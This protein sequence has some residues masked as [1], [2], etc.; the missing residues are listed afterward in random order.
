[1]DN[2]SSVSRRKYVQALL[3]STAAGLAGCN[4][5]GSEGSPGNESSA[6]Q[7]T[8]TA[9]TTSTE[10]PPVRES[11]RSWITN[12]PSSSNLNR[13]ASSTKEGGITWFRELTD[14]RII[15]EANRMVFSGESFDSPWI[16][17]A[18]SISIP[19]MVTDHEVDAP[20]DVYETYD[21]R[22]TYWDGTPLDAEARLYTDRL[23]YFSDG[24]KYDDT[25]TKNN[26][27][28]SQWEFHWWRNK[29][30]VEGQEPDPTN[31]RIL[32]SQKLTLP[33]FHPDF[34]T[35]WV[36]KFRDAS[37]QDEVD[38]INSDLQGR[39]IS[40]NE[41]ADNSW[42][43]GLYEIES[44]D[45]IS[46]ERLSATLR[47]D[48]PN[49]HAEIPELELHFANADRGQ[50]LRGEG[51]IDIGNGVITEDGSI[52][53]ESLPDHIQQVDQFLQNG[54]DQITF[55]L[56]NQHLAN[57]WVRRAIIAAVDW[58]QASINGF[59]PSGAVPN[60]SHA[61]MLQTTATSFFSEE[62]LDSLYDW[63]MGSD[64]ELAEKWMQKAGYT[65]E[66]GIWTSP[67]G[68]Q[69]DLS[70]LGH[71]DIPEWSSFI[72]TCQQN[73]QNL[74]FEVGV[75]F[76]D[77][78]AWNNAMKPENL[79]YDLAMIWTPG[80]TNPWDAYWTNGVFWSEPLVGGDP[81]DRLPWQVDPET[82]GP[83]VTHD[84]KDMQN[85]PLEV[86]IP[87]NPSN[88]DAAPNEAGRVPDLSGNAVN[89]DVADLVHSLRAPD[90]TEEE[91]RENARKCAR[92]YNFYLPN[93]HFHQ[94]T[95]GLWGNV[96]AF[97]FPPQGHTLNQ[98]YKQFG[99]AD[100][101]VLAGTPRLKY[102]EEF[103]PPSQ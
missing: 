98:T 25:M 61:G 3:A 77:P 69:V 72:Q 27:A 9:P 2:D 94:Y 22:L 90:I 101:S 45:D 59:G 68:T 75:T 63:P 89:I 84:T 4:Q 100:F 85:V 76:N 48:H 10:G 83:D 14:P 87:E 1:M 67:D 8:S 74:G 30:E 53:R 81:N 79:N 60:T 7:T 46:A 93:F 80:A 52:T 38:Q 34:T 42:G 99:G 15:R 55:N 43:S 82:T 19:T 28:V 73:L 86:E 64:M 51:K 56:N 62:F 95:H 57:L 54:G 39:S 11:I 23:W 66:G 32:E 102:D 36:Q 58:E 37:N 50:I 18:D 41:Y 29:G 33:P 13:W 24:G 31:A 35:N 96:R 16:D 103:Q 40:Y 49:E 71:G 65:K 12:N 78:T 44:S 20:F 5:G 17:G 47:D 26:E 92:F 21:D 6:N 70:F 91:F 88:I 97:N